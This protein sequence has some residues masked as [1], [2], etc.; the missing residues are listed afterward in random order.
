MRACRWPPDP[1]LRSVDEAE[2]AA[3]V[4]GLV[5][6]REWARGEVSNRWIR[7]RGGGMPSDKAYREVCC[8]EGC[9]KAVSWKYAF[10]YR[11]HKMIPEDQRWDVIKAALKERADR[12]RKGGAGDGTD[13]GNGWATGESP[14]VAEATDGWVWRV[15]TVRVRTTVG[16]GKS[17]V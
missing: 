15:M 6:A 14:E 5:R 3:V 13:A 1:V 4:A 2:A 16:S 7:G 8:W 9:T 17:M 11:H 10:C 12:A